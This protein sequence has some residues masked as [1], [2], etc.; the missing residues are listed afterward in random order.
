MKMV[1]GFFI[2]LVMVTS[3]KLDGSIY[4]SPFLRTGM[5]TVIVACLPM[6]PFVVALGVAISCGVSFYRWVEEKAWEVK[7]ARIR[8]AAFG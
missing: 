8:V 4:F 6:L 3:G 1:C 5:A 2:L 7:A